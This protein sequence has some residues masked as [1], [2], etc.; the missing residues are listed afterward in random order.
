[1]QHTSRT[2][3]EGKCCTG[4]YYELDL[5]D[6]L[7]LSSV[8]LSSEDEVFPLEAFFIA[9]LTASSVAIGLLSV[10][11]CQTDLRNPSFL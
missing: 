10:N 4:K 9:S 5:E 8:D 6:F 7:A 11:L 2:E 1:M 3:G